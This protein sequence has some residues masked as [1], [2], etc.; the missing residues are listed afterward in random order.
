MDEDE[1]AWE[2]CELPEPNSISRNGIRYEAMPFGKV[3]GLGQ[4]GG[5][6]A[7]IDEA[8]DKELWLLKVYDVRYDPEKEEDVQEIF[9]SE[10]KP[11][12]ENLLHVFNER[13]GHYLVNVDTRVVI[14]LEG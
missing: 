13:G 12:D 2:R 5:Y 9:I 6:I 14:Q 4:N 8:S 1:I 7:A 11:G 3:R 10:L